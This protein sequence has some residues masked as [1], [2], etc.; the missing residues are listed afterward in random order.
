MYVFQSAMARSFKK[1]LDKIIT[2]D[3][4]GYR[5]ALMM[6]KIFDESSMQDAYV[7]D[8]EVGG[9]GLLIQ[10]YEGQDVPMGTLLEGFMKRYLARTFA[11]GLAISEEVAEDEKYDQVLASAQR[12]KRACYLTVDVDAANVFVRATDANY[13]GGDGVALASAS[14]TLPNG[15][16]YS[17]LF[18][19]AM[20]PSRVAV[21]VARAALKKIPSH[22]GIAGGGMLK[23]ECIVCPVEQESAW[24][25]ILGSQHAPEPGEFNAINVVNRMGMDLYPWVFWSNTTTNWAIKTSADNGLRFLWRRRP[26]SRSWINN[27]QGIMKYSIDAR[28]DCGFS[29]PRAIYFSN[30]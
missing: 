9:P 10:K 17:N 5:A 15:N 30:A 21:T 25:V 19:V 13:V 7:D 29:D 6:P 20:S 26:R 22:D 8:L 3:G 12:L 27:E 28:W 23:G 16:T 14:H 4:D 24:E 2:D 18:S 1:T 11:L